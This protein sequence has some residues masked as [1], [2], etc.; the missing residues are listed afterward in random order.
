MIVYAVSALAFWLG[1]YLLSRPN[2]KP[3]LRLAGLGVVGYAGAIAAEDAGQRA[4]SLICLALSAALWLAAIMIEL[5]RQRTAYHAAA[6]DAA[7]PA[8]RPTGLL[9][10]AAIFFGLGLGALLLFDDSLPRALLLYG[11][12]ADIFLLGLAIA[13]LDAFDEGEQLWRD[14]ARS[15]AG[16]A[17]ATALFG[18]LLW[19]A[20]GPGPLLHVMLAAAIGTQTLGD[21]LQT[22]LDRLAFAR[23]PALQAARDD[24]RETGAALPRMPAVLDAASMDDAEFAKL[25][26]RALSHYGDLTK[27]TASPLTHLAIVQQ[28]LVSGG[29]VDTPLARAQILKQALGECIAQLKPAGERG[30]GDSDEW[31]HYNAL[32]WPY[33][34]GI[35]PYAARLDDGALP[36]DARAARDWFQ[37][38]VPER[39]LYNWQTAAARLVARQL[40]G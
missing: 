20:A 11:I 6:A 39:T 8:R 10:A 26:R 16:A 1:A 36:P 30:F 5:R 13:R 24:L 32:Y 31:R 34:A 2:S 25:T 18:G 33:V 38:A 19:L 40:K 15:F 35:K 3:A 9:V 28:R 17:L 23:Q 27:L 21:Q 14:L 22:A 7:A 37:S 12:G 4:G 29:A